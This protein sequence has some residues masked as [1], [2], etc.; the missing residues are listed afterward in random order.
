MAYSQTASF[1]ISD[2]PNLVGTPLGV[3]AA[4]FMLL[5]MLIKM[6]VFGFHVWLP[7]VHAEHPTCIAGILAVI[8]GIEGYLIARIFVQQLFGIFELFSIPLMAWAL[9]TMVY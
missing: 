7:W 6:A 8:V 1:M 3:W 2:L 4:L 5:G 9:V